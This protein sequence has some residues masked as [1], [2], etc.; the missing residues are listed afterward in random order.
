[1][2][3]TDTATSKLSPLAVRP[4]IIIDQREKLPLPFSQ[5]PDRTLGDMVC[6]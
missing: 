6:S 1:M 5:P 2:A 4:V 3:D